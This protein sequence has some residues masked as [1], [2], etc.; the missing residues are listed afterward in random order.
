MQRI[1]ALGPIGICCCLLRRGPSL[2]ERRQSNSASGRFSVALPAAVPGDEIAR[3]SGI[4]LRDHSR[5]GLFGAQQEVTIA[6]FNF[7]NHISD[8]LIFD[9]GGSS[10]IQHRKTS[11]RLRYFAK[12]SEPRRLD[13]V[14][15]LA[16]FVRGSILE[17]GRDEDFSCPAFAFGL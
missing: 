5:A 14:K 7:R 13:R 9:K 15:P 10:A 4:C 12:Q 8:S 2:A 16:A 6:D 11:D 1:Q 17:D 3:R